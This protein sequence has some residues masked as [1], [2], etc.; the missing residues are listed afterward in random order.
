M[1]IEMKLNLIKLKEVG[2]R[3]KVIWL[4]MLKNKKIFSSAQQIDEDSPMDKE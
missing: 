3:V 2:W 4:C 1:S